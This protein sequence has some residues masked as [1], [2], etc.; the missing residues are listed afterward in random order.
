M[1]EPKAKREPDSW[2]GQLTWRWKLVLVAWSTSLCLGFAL[3]T[4]YGAAQGSQ[5]ASAMRWP[6]ASIERAPHRWTLVMLAHPKCPC[7]QASIAEL[8]RL[9]TGIGGEVDAHVVFIAPSESAAWAKT[10]L[11]ERAEAIPGVSVVVDST[12]T[13][14]DAFGASTSGHVML[15]DESGTLRF[16]G[17][18]T[19]SR[20]HEGSNLGSA[21]ISK[22]VL[23]ASESRSSTPVYGCSLQEP[24]DPTDAVQAFLVG[25][26]GRVTSTHANGAN[27]P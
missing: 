26:L 21:R 27:K 24:K 19:Q 6:T 10:R 14:S 20:G 1:G 17:G 12:G 18:I 11:Y 16:D 3:L 25:L 13:I 15:Y 8:A 4:A 7:T 5:G 9:M 23:G 22:L 2:R